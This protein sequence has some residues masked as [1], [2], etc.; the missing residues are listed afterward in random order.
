MKRLSIVLFILFVCV[1]VVFG[2][3]F[4][5]SQFY[6]TPLLRNPALSGIFTGDIR[7]IGVF[8]NQWQSVTVPFKTGAGS[9]EAKFP[10]KR[11]NDWITIGF[12]AT[13]DRAGDL[14]LSRTQ[15]LPAFNYHKS[16][17][18]Y[19]ETYL[20]AGIIGGIVSSTFDPTKV[21]TDIQ[22]QNGG[23]YDP[24]INP[25][26]AVINTGN[27]YFDVGVGLSFT[28]LIFRA[29]HVYI[30]SAVY[31]INT[32]KIAF[33]KSSANATILG[34]KWVGNIGVNTNIGTRN[35]IEFY[36]DYAYQSGNQQLYLGSIYNFHF[37][38]GSSFYDSYGYAGRSGEGNDKTFYFG[39]LYRLNDAIIPVVGIKAF[40]LN[41][42]VSYDI[43]VSKLVQ[44]SKYR[45]GWELT[46]AYIVRLKH[47]AEMLSE[48]ACPRF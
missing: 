26:L 4:T 22:Y 39:C 25:S 1:G 44:S 3:D 34:R 38:T 46:L 6:Q 31:H 2:Q 23:S 21:R 48:L 28:S 16:F 35:S 40:N 24:N 45:G 42:G 41:L 17:S 9:V 27:N 13:Y 10:I 32:P 7:A 11:W 12:Q 18:R 30:G 37:A 14:N 47:R 43:N 33:D 8:R 29:T 36:L 5:F 15:L 20:S 19:R